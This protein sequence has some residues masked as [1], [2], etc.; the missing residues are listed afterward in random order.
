MEITCNR[1]HQTVQADNCY[2]PACGLPQLVY[3]P[4][5]IPVPVASEN[6]PEAV[7]DASSIDWR[8]A[9]RAAVVFAVPAGLFSSGISPLSPFGLVWMTTGAALAVVLYIRSQKPAWITIGAGARIGLVTGLLAAWLTFGVSGGWLFVQR[10]VL[11][12]PTQID[13]VYGAFVEAFQQKVHDSISRMAPADAA[14]VQ[15]T[16]A[17]M[18]ALILSPEGHAG[19]WA[20]SIAG[21][22]LFLILFAVG[23]GALGARFLAR[24]RRPEV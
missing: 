10:N 6:W 9:M 12:Q 16:I 3:S 7:R 20:L 22:C 21:N 17:H 8:F 24:S 18:Q 19:I 15:P 5:S 2:C 13:L 11:H 1:C 23:G 14:Q 4:D